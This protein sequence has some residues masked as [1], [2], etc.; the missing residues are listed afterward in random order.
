LIPPRDAE[1]A[2]PRALH[3]N[4]RELASSTNYAC[5]NG[6]LVLARGAGSQVDS[7]CGVEIRAGDATVAADAVWQVRALE[8]AGPTLQLIVVVCCALDTSIET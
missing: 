6:V 7:S 4:I 3:Q 2:V 5:P 1:L 8:A